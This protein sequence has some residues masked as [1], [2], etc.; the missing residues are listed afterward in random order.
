M[1]DKILNVIDYMQLSI[2]IILYSLTFGLTVAVSKPRRSLV[3]HFL[4]G[5]L[6][7]AFAYGLVANLFYGKQ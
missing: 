5:A 4:Y 3:R 2:L 6:L 1:L 7:P